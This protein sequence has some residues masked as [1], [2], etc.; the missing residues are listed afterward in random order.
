MNLLF[1]KPPLRDF[2]SSECMVDPGGRSDLIASQ[3]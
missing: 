3:S 1:G 2:R